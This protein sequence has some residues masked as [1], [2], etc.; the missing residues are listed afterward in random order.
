MIQPI[1][2]GHGEVPAVPVLI[3]RI[4]ALMGIPCAPVGVPIRSKRSL[5]A[6]EDG[7]H[8]AVRVAR[9]QPGCKAILILFD[10]DD[11]CPAEITPKLIHWAEAAA[12]PLP[13]AVVLA[14]REYEAWFLGCLEGLLRDRHSESAVAYENDP[15]A[16][17]DARGELEA[18]FGR[19][20]YYVEKEDQPSLTAL[21]DLS[22]VHR[23]C[24][25]FRKMV[26]ET[27]RLL[28]ACG[29]NPS[30]WPG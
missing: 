27:D 10:A 19:E 23:R 25:S 30:Q 9:Q 14:N 3:R 16:K 29:L 22:L 28:R 4:G 20:F 15:E 17:R 7:M 12:A 21:A 24:R 2:E 13:C 6:K 1:V 18:R 5:L 26:K 11:D 8:R